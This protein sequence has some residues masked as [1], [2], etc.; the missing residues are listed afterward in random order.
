MLACQV[1]VGLQRIVNNDDSVL[2]V[3]IFRMFRIIQIFQHSGIVNNGIGTALLQGL[4]SKLVAIEGL[5]LQR[6]KDTSFGTVTRI[7]S[8]IGVLSV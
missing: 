5:A 1:L 8:D 4:H 2:K 7:G 6:Q 3:P